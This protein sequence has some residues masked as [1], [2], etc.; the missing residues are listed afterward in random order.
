[1]A[2]RSDGSLLTR[3]GKMPKTTAA[4][5]AAAA[6]LRDE[7]EQL[8]FGPPVAYVYD[9]LTYAWE[10]HRLY[11]EKFARGPRRLLLVGM[12]PGPFG[13]AQTGVPF[14]E[15]HLV[16][17][18][19]G[20]HAPV[21]KPPR[22]HSARPVLGFQCTRSEVSGARLWGAI[23]KKNPDPAS[24]FADALVLNY[25]PLLFLEASGRN[26]T[27]D[28]LPRRERAPLEAACDAHLLRAVDVLSPEVVLGVGTWAEKRARAVVG[29]RARVGCL[30]HPSP[31]SPQANRGWTKL[32]RQA[33]RD[34]GLE[35]F[36]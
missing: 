35:P 14:G 33:L 28:K 2:H 22:E 18:W 20:I 16:A 24:F 7:V 15:V 10:S 32:A 34:A 3:M 21:G 6:A 29:S 26:L 19:M 17:A 27:P 8:S 1:M 11:L 4:L 31:A 5:V 12:N 9:P 30:P 36:L 25:C 13:M 23:R